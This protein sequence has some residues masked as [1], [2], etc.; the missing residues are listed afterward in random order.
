MY[1]HL[2]IYVIQ[3]TD[4][5]PYVHVQTYS[6]FYSI[7]RAFRIHYNATLSVQSPE[8]GPPPSHLRTWVLPPPF[9]SWGIHTR[10]RGGGGWGDP[11]PTK[12]QALWYSMDTIISLRTTCKLSS[13][14][15]NKTS[16]W[17]FYYTFTRRS[18]WKGEFLPEHEQ[19]IL[20]K[21]CIMEF[22]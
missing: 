19:T 4:H 2:Y 17:F 12:G 16:G 1:H 5:Q 9:G 6:L 13:F 14:F 15:T 21:I 3:K 22:V 20:S 8:L 10:L 11:I 18:K 7:T